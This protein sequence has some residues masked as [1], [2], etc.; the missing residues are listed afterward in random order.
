MTPPLESRDELVAAVNALRIEVKALNEKI[1]E[2]PV[3]A[4]VSRDGRNRAWKFFGFA[5]VVILVSQMINMNLVSYCFLDANGASKPICNSIPG[6]G[7]AM[8]QNDI[9][10]GRFEF[11]VGAIEENQR[12]LAETQE[13]IRRLQEEIKSMKDRG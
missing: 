3:R 4:E 6:Y 9:R 11:V 13:T 10:L 8:R 7:E 5:A 2:R 1:Q 12:T